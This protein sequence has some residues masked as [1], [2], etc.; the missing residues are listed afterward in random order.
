[1]IARTLSRILRRLHADRRG[2]AAMEFA[3]VAPMLVIVFIGGF[4]ALDAVTALRKLT[5]ATVQVAN[6]AARYATMS[7]SDVN[8]VLGAATVIMTP[9]ATTPLSIVLSEITLDANGQ[10]TVTWSQAFQG[11]PL[12]PG[13]PV[14]MPP[15]FDTPNTSYIMVQTTY[16]YIPPLGGGLIGPVTMT[17]Q[18]VMVPR[19]SSSIPF[20]G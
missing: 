5:D 17:R 6:V 8:V 13:A 2:I 7:Q 18:S 12:S 9:Y 19:A 10:A 20:T 15:G 14:A 3:A 1:M 4:Q 11:T 16:Q